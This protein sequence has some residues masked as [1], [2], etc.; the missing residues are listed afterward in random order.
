M[1]IPRFQLALRSLGPFFVGIGLL[2]PSVGAADSSDGTSGELPVA[3]SSRARPQ[4]LTLEQCLSLAEQNFPRIH[5]ARARLVAKESQL[6]EAHTAPFSEFNVTAG[7]GIVPIWR[8]TTVYS[9]NSDAALTPNMGLAWQMGIEG[10]VPLWTFGKISNLWDAAEANVKVG[11]HELKKE[12]D[13]IRLEVVRAYF[14][15][16]LA[17]D[18]L[19]LLRQV[20][21]QLNAHLDELQ[22]RVDEGEGDDLELL[23][24]R[25]QEAELD[26]RASEAQKSE[27]IALAGLRFFT[28]S[29]GAVD[30][31]DVPLRR[32]SHQLGP[33]GRYLEA[34]RLYR[35]EINMVRA[36]V[37]ARRAQLQIEQ[38]KYYPDIGLG[39]SAKITR[40]AEMTDQRNP[41][42]HDPANFAFTGAG[43]VMRWKLDFFPQS[44]RIAKAQADLEEMRAKERFALG[45]IAVEVEKAFAEAED[46]KQR[47]D[48]WSRASQFA[49]QWLIKVQQGMDL[50]LFEEKEIVEPA[51][52]YA[53]KKF[54]EMSAV[55]DYNVAVAQL[56]LSTGWDDIS[57]VEP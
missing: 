26:A 32:V 39:L 10:V 13:A 35:P 18:S 6:R 5:E 28:G 11:Q 14:G 53:L 21:G 25:M 45:G 4:L 41:F 27:R 40:A 49:K 9:P 23:K 34:A 43:L 1:R 22:E 54:S 42:A 37:I 38:A 57:L 15:V 52:E 55:F 56:A 8:G 36:G 12:K 50:G 20:Q 17:R 51:K 3:S 2:S 24:I 46:A 48:A 44:A 47:L 31:P 29:N 16:Q 33:L 30:I 19:L 7:A